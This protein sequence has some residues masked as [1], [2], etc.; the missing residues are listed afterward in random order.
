[1]PATWGCVC[2]N[3]LPEMT[4]TMEYYHDLGSNLN[5]SMNIS[6]PFCDNVMNLNR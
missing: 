5:F 2:M 1:V 6:V 3:A 4:R